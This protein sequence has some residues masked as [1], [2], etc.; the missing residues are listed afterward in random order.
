MTKEG[1]RWTIVSSILVRQFL[2]EPISKL[3]KRIETKLKLNNFI[4]NCCNLSAIEEAIQ[5]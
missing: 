2:N 4:D 1:R 3:K 5:I